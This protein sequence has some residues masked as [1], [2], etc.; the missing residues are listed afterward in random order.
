VRRLL[1]LLPVVVLAGCGSERTP[2]PDITHAVAPVGTK[3]Y[4]LSGGAV[5]FTAPGNWDTMPPE[6][7][8]AGGVRSRTATVAVWRYERTEPLPDSRKALKAAGARLTASAQAHDP[9]FRVR[10]TRF[11][12][13]GGGA[14]S[15]ELV[16]AQ[17]IAGVPVDVRSTHLFA[18]GAEVVVDAYAPPGDFPRVDEQVFLPLLRSL[19]V[20]RR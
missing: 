14:P 20:R 13:R 9:T 6:G 19:K 12:H 5:R 4:E 15:I 1:L 11:R 8:L 3:A 17:T 16:G 2:V 18:D 7:S 10:V